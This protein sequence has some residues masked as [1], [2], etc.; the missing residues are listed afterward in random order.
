MEKY[1]KLEDVL[2]ILKTRRLN[3]RWVSISNELMTCIY[4]IKKLPVIEVVEPAL[5]ADWVPAREGFLGSDYW[6]SNCMSWADEGNSGHYNVLTDYC[7]HCGCKMRR[8]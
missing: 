2:D 3:T 1:V 5:E 4:R 7:Q 6:C 8:K